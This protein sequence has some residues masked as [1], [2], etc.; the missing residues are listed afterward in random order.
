M[1]HSTLELSR[2]VERVRSIAP[3]QGSVAR[4]DRLPDGRTSLVF[5]VNH[6]GR[7]DVHVV[8]PRTRALFKEAS[9]FERAVMLD[10]KPGWSSPLFGVPAQELT[11]GYVSLDEV[12][13]PDA[14]RLTAQ[15]VA[16]RTT[17]EVVACIERA[18]PQFTRPTWEP[19]S[20]SLARR[21]ARLLEEVGARVEL[22]AD[23]LGVTARHLR[24]V[25][26][27]N[28]GVGPKDYARS[29]RLKRAVQLSAS[30]SD[31]SR[32]AAEAG[33]YDQAHL[34]AEFRALVGLTPGSFAKRSS[35]RDD[36]TAA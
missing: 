1:A 32:V 36:D 34:I 27:T 12:W 10:F 23:R 22:V 7:G 9:G 28:I 35:V 20:A 3:V 6:L 25:F 24:R 31:W 33:Y 4:I 2:F 26:L 18:L 19:S 21:A 16:A 30:S 14:G 29:A 13:G 17:S 15:L 5:R 11:D 8:G